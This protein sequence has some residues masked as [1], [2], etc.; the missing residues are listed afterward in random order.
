MKQV[1]RLKTTN[2][3]MQI[4]TNFTAAEMQNKDKKIA[5][6][7][8]DVS[9]LKTASISLDSQLQALGHEIIAK[10]QQIAACTSNNSDDVKQFIQKQQEQIPALNDT[11]QQ[12]QQ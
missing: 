3:G 12:Q 4:A 9:T 7:C 2:R 1:P 11:L 8:T 6:L 10:D 5:K